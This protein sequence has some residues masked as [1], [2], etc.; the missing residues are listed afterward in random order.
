MAKAGK[1]ANGGERRRKRKN[2]GIRRLTRTPVRLWPDRRSHSRIRRGRAATTVS[3]ARPI[4]RYEAGLRHLAKRHAPVAMRSPP[5][6]SFACLEAQPALVER[7]E[8]ERV[9]S[10]SRAVPNSTT[11]PETSAPATSAGRLFHL[12]G[13][14]D[15]QGS[16]VRSLSICASTSDRFQF[17]TDR[18]PTIG[19]TRFAFALPGP[20]SRQ[21]SRSRYRHRRPCAS[22]AAPRAP[23]PPEG[24]RHGRAS[25]GAEFRR[26]AAIR[27]PCASSYWPKSTATCARRRP[28]LCDQRLLASSR[29]SA[30]APKDRGRG[31]G[32]GHDGNRGYGGGAPGLPVEEIPFRSTLFSRSGG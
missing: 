19:Q 8:D 14:Q 1:T 2:P 10:P 5:R 13:L 24:A 29:R 26:G 3:R 32:R 15:R 7:D 23:H 31:S 11:A 27:D 17:S 30:S 22:R 6:P 18:A 21:V 16:D 20:S 4:V 28:Q 12:P 9:M 25:R